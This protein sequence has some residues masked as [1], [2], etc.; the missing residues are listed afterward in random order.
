MTH[1]TGIWE[2]VET[3]A[4]WLLALV[5][6]A[7]LLYA[8]WA[9]FHPAEY[10]VRFDLT[11]PLTLENFREALSQAPFPR[12]FFNT[13]VLVTMLLAAQFES[14]LHPLTVML[15]LPLSMVGALG[16]LFLLGMFIMAYN[17]W[18]TVGAGERRATYPVIEPA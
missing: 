8:F 15:A 7:P 3:A 18:K 11:A 4:A 5:W 6:A 13:F 1:R 17:V 16:A 12:Y 14:L 2:L 9:S 10:A